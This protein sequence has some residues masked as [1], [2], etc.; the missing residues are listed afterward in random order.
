VKENNLTKPDIMKKKVLR[1]AKI[2]A[3]GKPK[4]T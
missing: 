1:K 4:K 3:S 2:A